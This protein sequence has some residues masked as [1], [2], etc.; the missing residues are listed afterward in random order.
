LPG[1][2]LQHRAHMSL[3]LNQRLRLVRSEES[4]EGRVREPRRAALLIVED[5]KVRRIVARVIRAAGAD[6]I[7]TSTAD[8]ARW[9]ESNRFDLFVYDLAGQ[10]DEASQ[11][12]LARLTAAV[13][14]P[15]VLLN[16]H[17][18]DEKLAEVLTRTQGRNVIARIASSATVVDVGEL[19][20]T[21]K[22]LLD[23][24]LFGSE[25]YLRWG[26]VLH[27]VKV[28]ATGDK[29]AA[30]AHLG[31]FLGELECDSRMVG[32][33]QTVADE[34]IMNALYN[35]P[36]DASGG[37]RYASLSRR[38]EVTLAA[39]EAATLE[40][41]SDGRYVAVACRDPFGSLLPQRVQESLGR[42]MRA[43][44][45]QVSW[46]S[47]GAGIG[48]YMVYRSVDQL[49]VNI[50]PGRMTELIAIVDLTQGF[51]A[52]SANPKSINIFSVGASS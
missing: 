47:G 5:L 46:E 10:N 12:A 40:Y 17:V 38:E 19:L 45:A 42:S 8:A 18:M 24:D 48:I 3:A 6:V 36:R 27:S 2:L 51:R 15:L 4:D 23:R 11:E 1:E 30:L 33:L 25:K 13:Q 7:A 52:R 28:A 29:Q 32:Q 16:A 9:M 44:G 31:S 41:G 21:I 39:H 22:K 20:V 35:A 34:F 26:C 50:D 14:A 37:A 49:V 43:G